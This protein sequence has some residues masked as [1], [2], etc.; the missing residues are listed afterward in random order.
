MSANLYQDHLTTRK[1]QEAQAVQLLVELNTLAN[2][3]VNV[4]FFGNRIALNLVDI[5]AHHDKNA[6]NIA[7]TL[8]FATALNDQNLSH[9]TVDLGQALKAGKQA[10]SFT[11]G[12]EVPATDVVLY[13]FG[14]IG[15]I[16]ARLL[17]SRPASD[18]GLQLKAIVVRPAGEADA[19]L[20]DLEKRASLLER[21][22]VHGWFDG[23][24][25]VDKANSGIIANGRFIKV[26]YAADPSEIDYTSYGIDNA[27]IIDN[28]GKW[29]DEAGLG[30]H[31]Q[32]K[33]AKK[34]L[35]TAPASGDIK[36]IVYNVNDDTIGNDTI[37]S[38]ASC[39]T[40]AITPTLKLLN[41]KYGIENGHMETIHA[42]TNDQNLV[43]NHHK[44][45]RRGRAAT[46][47]MVMTSTGA[48]KAVSKAIPEL[49]GKLSGSSVRVP[50]PNVSLAILNLNFKNPVN[51]S[52]ELNAFIKEA[53]ESEQ[54]QAQIAYS[55]SDEAVS[56]DFVG[57]E[58]VAIWDAK[59]TLAQENR[60]VMYLWYDNEMGYSTQVLRVAETMAKNA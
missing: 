32:S 36:N 23:S 3:G 14:R 7:D 58:K 29:K 44:A 11:S 50:T 40:N 2:K 27:L 42:F 8:A 37:V 28:T 46:L 24:V 31:L 53:S 59:S 6:L 43:D 57:C 16:L 19:L 10:D 12:D 21:D 4:L 48:A 55:D 15:R 13:G 34:V 5:I 35:L 30:K 60:A 39:T 41:D 26:I 52:D 22:S 33:G 45:E 51:S 54:W 9:T 56:T 17:M 38:A 47:N 20:K 18:K 49:K 25:V 1:N